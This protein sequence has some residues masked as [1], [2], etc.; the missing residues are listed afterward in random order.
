MAAADRWTE[1][2]TT[3]KYYA[4]DLSI[5]GHKKDVNTNKQHLLLFPQCLQ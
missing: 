2:L 3:V 5:R 1:R 4:P